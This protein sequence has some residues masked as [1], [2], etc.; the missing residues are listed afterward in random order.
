MAAEPKRAPGRKEVVESKGAPN[1]TMGME[2]MRPQMIRL[3]L[4]SGTVLATPASERMLSMLM[5][6]SAMRI[7]RTA[8]QKVVGPFVVEDQ[9]VVIGQ[10]TDIKVNGTI[11]YVSDNVTVKEED[12]A[13]V[14]YDSQVEDPAMAYI[15]Y[16][17]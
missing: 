14:T 5:M 1:S 15:V 10:T 11:L 16:K 12:L 6:K 2:I 8:A 3:H 7:V 13:A 17:K 4:P 9:V